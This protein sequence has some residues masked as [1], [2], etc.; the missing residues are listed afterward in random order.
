MQTVLVHC[1]FVAMSRELV[2]AKASAELC[3]PLRLTYPQGF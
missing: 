3:A 2:G 1:D